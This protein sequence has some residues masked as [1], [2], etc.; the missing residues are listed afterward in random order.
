MALLSAKV[1]HNTN[2]CY[3]PE[4]LKRFDFNDRGIT[5]FNSIIGPPSESIINSVF[6]QKEN[7]PRMIQTEMTVNVYVPID[8]TVKITEL[9]KFLTEQSKHVSDNKLNSAKRTVSTVLVDWLQKCSPDKVTNVPINKESGLEDTFKLQISLS[10]KAYEKICDELVAEGYGENEWETAHQW[11]PQ[12]IQE[13]NWTNYVQNP[14]NEDNPEVFNLVNS[15]GN[16]ARPPY[17]ITLRS[18][19]QCLCEEKNCRNM[20]RKQINFYQIIPGIMYELISRLS[21]QVRSHVINEDSAVKAINFIPRYCYAIRT[22]PFNEM[23]PPCIHYNIKYN[24]YLN[25]CQG[26]DEAIPVSVLLVSMY[27][28]CYTFQGCI[29]KSDNRNNLLIL[30]LRGLDQFGAMS[31][32]TMIRTMSTYKKKYICISFTILI[33]QPFL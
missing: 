32:K 18:I 6:K 31:K 22:S 19:T 1:S 28:A 14:F 5:G 25:M 24:K 2:K 26:N 10:T 16:E 9:T 3:I 29:D 23:H 20:S 12:L 11:F 30:A 27:N 33:L 7:R 21:G 8:R 17:R 4:T 15:T 13:D